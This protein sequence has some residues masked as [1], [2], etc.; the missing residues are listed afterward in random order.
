[1]NVLVLLGGPST[2]FEQAGHVYPKPLI[3]VGGAPMIERVIDCYAPL[4]GDD[5]QFIFVV[6]RQDDQRYHLGSVIRLLVPSAVVIQMPEATGGAA[7]TALLA[8]DHIGNDTPLV[9]CNGDQIV[10][11]DLASAIADF[12]ARQLDGGVIAFRAVHPRWSYVRCDESGLVVEASEKRPISQLATAGVYYYRRGLDFVLAAGESIKKDA[13]VD[14]AFYV[15]PTYNELILQG[16][17]VG[18]HEID[19]GRY[20]SLATPPGLV[21]YEDHLSR[22]RA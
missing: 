16:A 14:G 13:H 4:V 5:G 6:R 19:R 2:Q 17:R 8:I 7:C 3:E 12:R 10:E 1:M 22:L 20:H 11:A 9:I 18:V 21:Q 15:C